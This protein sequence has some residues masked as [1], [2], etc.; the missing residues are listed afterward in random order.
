MKPLSKNII[1]ALI[2]VLLISAIFSGYTL[3][4]EKPEEISM[5]TLVDEIQSGTVKEIAI[6]GSD[7]SISLQD[8]KKQK[9][10]KE[11]SVSLS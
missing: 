2:A 1:F 6:E 8:G 11:A 5:A 7:V 4:S 3:Q 10:R 9:T